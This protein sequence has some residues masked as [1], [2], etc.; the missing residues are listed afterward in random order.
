[1][2][3]E[4]TDKM[5]EPDKMEEQGIL[6]SMARFFWWLLLLA[7]LNACSDEDPL[8]P[9]EE[10][11]FFIASNVL[12][13]LSRAET[14]QLVQLTGYGEFVDL[15]ENG[16]TIHRVTYKTTFRDSDITAS[17]LVVIPDGVDGP[18]PLLSAH[19]GTIFSH[20]EAPS[21][22]SL[23]RGVTGF[24]LFSAAG[25]VS[26]IPDYLGYGESKEILHPYY[27]FK[28]TSL[29]ILDM[30]SA[31]KEFLDNQSVPFND[32]LFLVG[33]SAGGYATLA[34]HKAIENNST[35]GLTVTAS[36]AGA[37]GYDI[38]GV[39]D[40]I[41]KNETYS[42]PA[43]LAFIT[44]AAIQTN[45][46][47]DPLTDFFQEPYATTIPGLLDGSFTQSA[48]NN[49]LTTDLGT[50]FNTDLLT[51][52]RN[53]VGHQ[54]S[55]E[56]E[57]NSVDDWSPTTTIRLYHSPGDEIIP[58]G[59]SVETAARLSANGGTDVKFIEVGGNSHGAAFIPM[60]EDV[61]PWFISLR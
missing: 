53:G 6:T 27:N 51:G 31:T 40:E 5:E 15:V 41:L 54:L 21:E 46:W 57:R 14:Q 30:I 7:G 20:E 12:L 11:E 28:Y 23:A 39:M 61:V 29:A 19:H 24:E 36:A 16:F 18:F 55:D 58:I 8:P 59:N 44:Y 37:G 22:F 60:L 48:V 33:Y 47:P 34:T 49:A 50:L 25:F 43:Y 45:R 38:V 42:T 32:K 17:G 52:L 56:F 2:K 1:M 35:L 10:D 13:E 9:P 26:I 4:R 3:Y